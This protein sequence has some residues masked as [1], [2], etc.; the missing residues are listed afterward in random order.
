M[1][2][3][4]TLQECDVL[5]SLQGGQLHTQDQFR[6]R[7]GE[8]KRLE[9]TPLQHTPELEFR[10]SRA[11]KELGKWTTGV[12]V[13]AGAF[14]PEFSSGSVRIRS[15]LPRARGYFTWASETSRL[16]SGSVALVSEPDG[17]A[18][19]VIAIP[20]PTERGPLYLIL[21]SEPDVALSGTVGFPLTPGSETFDARDQ[22]LL[23]GRPRS[24]AMAR[25]KLFRVKLALVG[26]VG[27][28][29]LVTLVLFVAESRRS[30]RAVTEQ[31]LG[32][33]I[34]KEAVAPAKGLALAAILL[35]IGLSSSLVWFALFAG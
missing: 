7:A 35:A 13:V 32:E 12:P 11:G 18:S 15:P 26:Y 17:T 1:R 28:V 24:L 34:D 30:A 19:G 29:F 10:L 33:G 9:L 20:T 31:L 23:D 22:L 4:A 5:V 3:A 16:R 8:E 21:A 25:A 2:A 6:L 14:F 27:S